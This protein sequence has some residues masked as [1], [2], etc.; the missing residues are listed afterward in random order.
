MNLEEKR[1]KLNIWEELDM[2][3]DLRKI[4]KDKKILSFLYKIQIM[5]ILKIVHVLFFNIN[6]SIYI[7]LYVVFLL[8]YYQISS[9]LKL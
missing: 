2:K 9:F 5:L 4:K 8:K 7:I 3:W 6:L 1:Y